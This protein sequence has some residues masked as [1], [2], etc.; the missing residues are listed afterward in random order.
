MK[1]LSTYK[2]NG[3]P[4]FITHFRVNTQGKI[5]HIGKILKVACF[6]GTS[7]QTVC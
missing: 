2:I 5:I 7:S 3:P 4:K 1:I 6:V